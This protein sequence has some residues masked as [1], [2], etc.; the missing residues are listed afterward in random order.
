LAPAQGHAP[1]KYINQGGH[2]PQL[3]RRWPGQTESSDLCVCAWKE[4][5]GNAGNWEKPR[6]GKVVGG[7]KLRAENRG[8]LEN[9]G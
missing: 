2:S 4:V 7:G 6:V 8:V 3:I 5:K 1:H 9:L